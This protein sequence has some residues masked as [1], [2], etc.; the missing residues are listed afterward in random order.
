MIN[1]GD[2]KAIAALGEGRMRRL[3]MWGLGM[4]LLIGLGV[5]TG[6][7]RAGEDDEDKPVLR[8]VHYGR[9]PG[10][11]ERLWQPS[12][13]PAEK[14]PAEKKDKPAAEKP[15]PVV[16]TASMVRK[17]EQEAWER[18]LQVCLR[19]MDLANQNNDDLL[20]RQA[21]ELEQRAWAVYLQRTAHLPSGSVRG[22]SDEQILDRHLGNVTSG[23]RSVA[24]QAAKGKDR[25]SQS[26][27]VEGKR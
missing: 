2:R 13:K 11:M 1:R 14:K 20:Y 6:A 3:W 25:D 16:E 7:S 12:E 22:E 9:G 19:L 27:S 10:I 5:A 4:T 21:E 8:K 23:A 26:A 15:A 17:R 24:G 18:R